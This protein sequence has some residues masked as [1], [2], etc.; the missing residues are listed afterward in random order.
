MVAT[1]TTTSFINCTTIQR[2]TYSTAK[3]ILGPFDMSPVHQAGPASETLA[4]PLNSLENFRRIRMRGWVCSGPEISVFPTGILVR[5][6]ENFA[7]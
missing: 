3:A 1:I 5:G 2:S 7:V 4:L 6:L